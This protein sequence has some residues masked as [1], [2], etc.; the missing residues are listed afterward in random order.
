MPPYK[1][2][3]LQDPRWAELVGRHPHASVFHTT[4]WLE[5]LRRSYDD[6]STRFGG[7]PSDMWESFV[8]YGASC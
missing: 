6:G 4:G 7:W 5:A 8:K 2:D 3:P 1:N